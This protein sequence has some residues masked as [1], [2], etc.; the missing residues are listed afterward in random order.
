MCY[1]NVRTMVA[2]ASRATQ[3]LGRLGA[4]FKL[5]VWHNFGCIVKYNDPRTRT[6]ALY[7]I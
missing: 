4:L 7:A 2:C 3:E 5:H 1:L 6:V